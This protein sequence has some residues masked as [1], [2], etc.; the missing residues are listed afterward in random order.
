M[1]KNDSLVYYCI[2]F[3]LCLVLI[4]CRGIIVPDR[5]LSWDVMGYYLYLPAGFIYHDLGFK[6][7]SWIN[8][9]VLTYQPTSTLYQLTQ[10]DNGGTVIRYSMGLSFL[11]SPFFF[12]AHFYAKITGYQADG[13]SLPYQYFIAFGSL[14]YSFIGLYFSR[15]VL[16]KFFNEKLVSL[17]LIIIVLST[18]YIQI[19]SDAT[20]NAHGFLF[21]IYAVLI[22]FT[23][24]WHEEQKVN[25]AIRIGLAIGLIT[26]IR[27]NE[28][29]CLLIPL[30]WGVY[31]KTSLMEKIRLLLNHR[32]QVLLIGVLAFVV[33]LPQLI[34]WKVYTGQFLFYSYNN[35]GEGFDFLSPHT[36]KFLFS[37]R[38]GFFIYTPVMIFSIFG[39]Y[40]LY[41]RNKGVFYPVLIYF[42]VNLY[43][44]SSWTCWWYA[45]TTYSSRS[46]VSSFLLMSV[47]MGY[48]LEY[49]FNRGKVLRYLILTVI[50]VLSVINLFQFWQFN[51]GIIDAYRMTGKYYLA[52]FGKTH[53]NN[54]D[55]KLLLVERSF[56]E[57][58]H[59][60]ADLQFRK[61]TIFYDGFETPVKELNTHIESDT[62]YTGKHSLRMD[63]ILIY[64]PGPDIRY[65]DI[66]HGE[67]AWIRA[68]VFV[69][70][71]EGYNEELPCLV[72]TFNHK[73]VSYCWKGESPDKVTVKR[74]EWIK[75]S[76]DYMTPEVR[77]VK[78]DLKVFLWHRGKKMIYADDLKVE[79]F[80]P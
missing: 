38:K 23:I 33:F 15:K 48:F 21:A 22:W 1:K 40:R 77:S 56:E 43:I 66:T 10:A 6:D 58:E 28:I 27:P 42:I 9:I 31:N 34:Y 79:K 24:R 53:V 67:Y 69:Y 72:V 61:S 51:R 19:V 50:L 54:E 36:L 62:I 52:I 78:D 59:L 76:M 74:G 16:L 37:F 49:F 73:D 5:V 75:L 45:G 41:K 30:F 3:I 70:I 80:E 35:S 7:M 11:Y 32:Y 4:V 17:L 68:T 64:S 13:F 57:K 71:P 39:L 47:P 26:L 60:P 2:P 18:N 29:V 20:L 55:K 14:I 12:L 44:V 8:H 65:E 46:L 63:S 25:H